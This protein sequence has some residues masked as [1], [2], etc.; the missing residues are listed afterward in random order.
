MN[1]ATL[2]AFVSRVILGRCKPTDG[3]KLPEENLQSLN[4]AYEESKRVFDLQLDQIDKLDVK[5]GLLLGAA[6]VVLAILVQGNV[7]NSGQPASSL[8]LAAATL[9]A[10]SGMSS[11]LAL[12]VRTFTMVPNPR[13]LTHDD[14][15]IAPESSTKREILEGF[16]RYYEEAV[17][18]A[19][20]KAFYTIS[21]ALLLVVA[22]ACMVAGIAAN[23]A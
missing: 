12:W 14:S 3:F 9:V 10:L 7:Q 13:W 23:I 18:K 2:A 4:I 22:L 6:G 17:C 15:I 5:T 11:L 8:F 16:V 20:G 21:A 19:E 1:L